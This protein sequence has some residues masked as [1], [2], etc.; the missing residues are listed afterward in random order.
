M[1]DN[2]VG[3]FP[4]DSTYSESPSLSPELA[5]NVT[6]PSGSAV[7]LDVAD[8]LSIGCGRFEFILTHHMDDDVAVLESVVLVSAW[9]TCTAPALAGKAGHLIL[10]VRTEAENTGAS[11]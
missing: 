10:L 8:G 3:K 4:G 5:S 11:G 9:A 1:W 7:N 6:S 2:I